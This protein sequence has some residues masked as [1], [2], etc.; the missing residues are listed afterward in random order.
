MVSEALLNNTP[1]SRAG[2]Q[3]VLALPFHSENCLLPP[4][5]GGF[6]SHVVSSLQTS[7]GTA[8]AGIS[9][10]YLKRWRAQQ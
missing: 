1:L 8:A 9:K 10:G 4:E 7:S 6:R 5:T 2:H 3:A